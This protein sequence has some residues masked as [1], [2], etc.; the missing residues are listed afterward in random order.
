MTVLFVTVYSNVFL[1][2]FDNFSIL[3]HESKMYLLEIKDS[4]LLRR[5]KSSLNR[6]INS[7]PFYLFHKV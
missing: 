1:P 4:L 3:A 7:A 5:G 6:N 2:T